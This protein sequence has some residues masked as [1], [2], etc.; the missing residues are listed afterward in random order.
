MFPSRF[1][2]I[3]AAL[4]AALILVAAFDS[5][6]ASLLASLILLP[7]TLPWS[8]MLFG[9]F[10]W[11]IGH[12]G[13]GQFW[14]P[15]SL[16][17]LANAYILTGFGA[18]L[19]RVHSERQAGATL[20]KALTR[21]AGVELKRQRR[22]LTVILVLIT[23]ALVP[24]NR[25]VFPGWNVKVVDGQGQPAAAVSVGRSWDRRTLWE[26]VDDFSLGPTDCRLTDANGAVVFPPVERT[27][28]AFW[29]LMVYSSNVGRSS[30]LP[31]IE[32]SVSIRGSDGRRDF[33]GSI[34]G[35]ADACTNDECMTGHLETTIQLTSR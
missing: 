10:G 34:P 25:Q 28:T 31:W 27:R 21:S 3:Y 26:G 24:I 32:G 16:A 1:V 29:W 35:R 9:L 14:L 15:F 23:A 8:V 13:A 2:A 6:P 33:E 4:V 11:T 7:L 30:T 19:A 22:V 5:G 18:W 20:A 17:A 12:N